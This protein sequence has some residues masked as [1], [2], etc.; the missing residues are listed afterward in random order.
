[1][2][3]I[4]PTA[5]KSVINSDFNT[6]L[7]MLTTQ[8]KNQDPTN[9]M[10]SAD[11]AVQLATFSGVEQQVKTND[12]LSNLSSQF[13]VMGMSQLA[14]WVGQ[15]AR[16]PS[17][18]YL[19]NSD[20]TVTYSS[21]VTADRAVLAV[22]DANGNLVA[23]EDVPL[24]T[25]PHQWSGFD[26]KGVPLPNGVYSLTL[27][28][29]RSGQQIGAP[30]EVQAYSPIQEARSG[31]TG[32]MLVLAGGIEVA[33]ASVTALRVAGDKT[34]S[35]PANGAPVTGAPVTGTPA[36]SAPVTDPAAATGPTAGTGGAAV[37][38]PVQSQPDMS[39]S[40]GD[41]TAIFSAEPPV[42]LDEFSQPI[43]ET[44]RPD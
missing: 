15:E 3:P 27:E 2:Q 38:Q 13:G 14:A 4:A 9:P 37:D 6:F 29:Y 12:M 44:Y 39:P 25:G 42:T 18:V 7:K 10:D 31:P 24:G 32:T 26:A 40:L 8:I 28:S 1:M 33:A 35:P 36:P 16:A 43:P 20:V 21:Q 34:S 22:R 30:G 17:P 19:G 5:Q 23:R 41:D 11:F